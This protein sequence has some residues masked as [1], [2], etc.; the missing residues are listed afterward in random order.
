MF[1]GCIRSPKKGERCVSCSLCSLN[2]HYGDLTSSH[3]PLTCP[4]SLC[5]HQIDL[6]GVN[7]PSLHIAPAI[8]QRPAPFAALSVCLPSTMDVD[9]AVML[10]RKQTLDAASARSAAKVVG[11]WCLLL[12]SVVACSLTVG[13]GCCCCRREKSRHSRC[14]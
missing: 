7:N 1:L 5:S 9:V 8:H 10:I 12:A 4:L 3:N 11:Q 13:R 6:R 2:L 14:M